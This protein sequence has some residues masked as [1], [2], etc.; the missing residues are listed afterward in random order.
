MKRKAEGGATQPSRRQ[1]Q[2]S[3]DSCRRKKLKCDRGQPCGSCRTRAIACT[4]PSTPG[5]CTRD[6]INGQTTHPPSLATAASAESDATI[7]SL[8]ARVA[9]LEQTVYRGGAAPAAYSSSH[10]TPA[11]ANG[12]SYNTPSPHSALD[13]ERRQEAKF[14]D[15][16]IDRSKWVDQAG[17]HK[18]MDFRITTPHSM[19]NDSHAKYEFS[20]GIHSGQQGLTWLMSRKEALALF[21][22]FIDNAY[23]LLH[24]LHM[25]A[26]RLI[27]NQF[28]DQIERD[29][30][31]R[32][33]PDHAAL[34]L[35]IAATTAFFWDARVPCQHTFESEKA[36][37]Q[38]SLTWRLSALDLLG[39]VQK[40][41]IA[42][43]E[44]A[45]AYAIIAYL[46]YNVDGQSAQFRFLHA[47]S[48]AACREISMHLVDGPGSSDSVDDAA[49]REAKRRLWW[50]VTATDWLLAQCGGPLDGTYKIHPRQMSVKKPRNLND[51][52]LA[53]A[54]DGLTHP[55]EVPTQM[56]CFLQRL[57]L[58]EACRAVVDGYLPGQAEISDYEQVL[59]LD[60]FFE[61]ILV[62]SPPCLALHA[63]VP[64]GAPRLLCLQRATVHL[65]FHSRRARLHRPFLMRKDAD[66]RP[67]DARFHRS[68]EICIQ[69][70]R[71]VLEISMALLEKS[72]SEPP[73]TQPRMPHILNH[74]NH[75]QC[76]GSPVHRLGIV[77]NHLFTA[78]AILALD[79][80]VRM[81]RTGEQTS[82]AADG[83][84]QD[85]LTCSCRLLAA[86]G[87]E[88]PVA[89]DLVRGLTGVLRRYR[90]KVKGIEKW[91][92]GS[93][94]EPQNF[95]K[96]SNDTD[97]AILE[98]DIG[99][100]NSTHLENS[101]TVENFGLDNLWDDF[102]GSELVSED[103]EQIVTGLD[104]YY[105][106]P[107]FG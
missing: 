71:T 11:A 57:Q 55:P 43:L 80:S 59:A 48:V 21:H 78:C 63:P 33:S 97:R 74:S 14:L 47:S 4:T 82:Q 79:S 56:S 107:Q 40:S 20:S 99:A 61:D 69:S 67:G 60:Q 93:G 7:K 81:S 8:L 3:C 6:D 50:H 52:D 91:S 100:G 17:A 88:S 85:A 101:D 32:V 38:A 2:V 10:P 53:L 12:S 19:S 66:G 30:A 36:A 31:P 98:N 62:T 90:I 24:I 51:S 22:D 84:I 42:S 44:A 28:Y 15:S 83:D 96:S 1:P 54:V 34:I 16:A 41:G 86:A 26:T 49:T 95:D 39:V 87:K 35:G 18:V 106:M 72:L 104:S 94:A 64:P 29:S 73:D 9:V 37:Q 58:A 103:W 105:N 25:D 23:H 77:I 46:Y 102:L 75:E 13:N 5:T 76:P 27:I 45:Q 68:R 70:A 92:E 89:A 65:G